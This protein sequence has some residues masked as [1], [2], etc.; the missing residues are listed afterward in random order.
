METNHGYIGYLLTVNPGFWN[1]LPED[2][3][4]EL[5]AIVQEV[6]VWANQQASII[7][8]EGKQRII[9][10]DESEV[11]MLTTAELAEWQT[12]MRPVWEQFEGNIGTDLIDAA[13]AARQ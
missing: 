2:I 9:E 6:G 7:N 4:A 12:V 11:L 3:R 10:S 1:G 13:L 8:E 5:D